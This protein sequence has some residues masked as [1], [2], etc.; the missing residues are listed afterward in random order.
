MIQFDAP[1]SYVLL[2]S[3]LACAPQYFGL[4]SA[5]PWLA[6]GGIPARAREICPETARK[7]S[8]FF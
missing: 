6:L 7:I 4:R 1:A 8:A 2:R 3:T 5:I